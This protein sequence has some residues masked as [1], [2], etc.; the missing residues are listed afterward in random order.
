MICDTSNATSGKEKPTLIGMRFVKGLN[1][2]IGKSSHRTIKTFFPPLNFLKKNIKIKISQNLW[3]RE[4]G[5]SARS[6]KMLVYYFI[7]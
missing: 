7:G 1:S 3:V 4:A 6:F 5:C 2:V